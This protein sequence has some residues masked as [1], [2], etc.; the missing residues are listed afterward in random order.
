MNS[1]RAQLGKDIWKVILLPIT[2]LLLPIFTIYP[3]ALISILHLG[4]FF[5]LTI[6]FPILIYFSL[7]F[8]PAYS[9][10]ASFWILKKLVT[11]IEE[12]NATMV[13]GAGLFLYLITMNQT[14]TSVSNF[15]QYYVPFGIVSLSMISLFAYM[16]NIVD[17]RNDKEI[18]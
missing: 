14:I 18:F 3:S 4:G 13:V 2:F 16:I 17:V 5:V 7:R 10:G 8:I 15:V 1:Y 6:V 9:F 12:Q 11:D